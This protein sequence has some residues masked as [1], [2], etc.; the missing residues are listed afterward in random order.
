MAI[1]VGSRKSKLALKQ[2]EI[3][4]RCLEINDYEIVKF[5][6]EGD[7]KSAMGFSQFDKLNF[8]EDIENK[9]LSKEIDIAVHSA[10]DMPANLNMNFEN[11][12]IREGDDDTRDDWNK[13]IL[14]FRNDIEPI[15]KKDMKLGT[16]SLRRQMQAKFFLGA[17][18]VVNL[19]GNINTRLKRL[20]KGE[21][22]CIILA[23]AGCKRLGFEL[24]SILLDEHITPTPQGLICVQKNKDFILPHSE[25]IENILI[26]R[27]D[28]LDSYL[29]NIN[30]GNRFLKKIGADC[31]SALAVE[32]RSED[33]SRYYPVIHAEIYGKYEY[34]S[35]SNNGSNSE[36]NSI[37]EILEEFYQKGGKDLLNEHN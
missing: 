3:A 34:I 18:N 20:E 35:I 25:M 22:D 4:M 30:I 32:A 12:F 28:G 23:N 9:L 15:F 26:H 31:H 37:Q 17:Q 14:I 13:D 8:V 11:F 21:F 7:K 24:N 19:N 2:V 29:N 6:T 27:E 36:D 1:K 16:S 10:K 33:H 5:S